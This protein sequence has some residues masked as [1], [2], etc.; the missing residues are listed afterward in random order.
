MKQRFGFLGKLPPV[1]VVSRIPVSTGCR[2]VTYSSRLTT[3][4][5]D[6]PDHFK[7]VDDRMRELGYSYQG[8]YG[9]N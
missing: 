6:I 1:D 8:P 2:V 7:D 5:L 9:R 4:V 3:V